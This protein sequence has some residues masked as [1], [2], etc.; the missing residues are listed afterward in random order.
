MLLALFEDLRTPA[1]DLAALASALGELSHKPAGAALERFLRLHHAEPEGSDL[2]EALKASATALATLLGKPAKRE[3]QAVTESPYASAAL[4]EHAGQTLAA[5]EAPAAKPEKLARA[6]A[7]KPAM[8][9]EPPRPR[10]LDARLV[11][12]VLK[13]MQAKLESCLSDPEGPRST[14]IAIVVDGEGLPEGIFVTPT[15]LQ[16]CVE[17]V[18]RTAKFPKTQLGRQQVTHVVQRPTKAEGDAGP[19]RKRA[20]KNKAADRPSPLRP[21][22]PG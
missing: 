21:L 1:G 8:P 10:S 15:T 20:R 4:R 14:R 5:L 2:A 9:A 7:D 19:S 13:P 3:L 22:T 11:S 17:P 18:V 6:E 12:Q 16:A